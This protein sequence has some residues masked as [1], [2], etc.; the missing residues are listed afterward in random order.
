MSFCPDLYCMHEAKG[1]AVFFAPVQ[2]LAR[3]VELRVCQNSPGFCLSCSV[4]RSRDVLM[5]ELGNSTLKQ[6][7]IVPGSCFLGLVKGYTIQ[8]RVLSLW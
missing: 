2:T 7:R 6:P 8:W 3:F 1:L 4:G 5:A